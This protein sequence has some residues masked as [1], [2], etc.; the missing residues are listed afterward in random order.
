MEMQRTVGW[1]DYGME[2]QRIVGWKDYGMEMQRIVGGKD[3]GMEMQNAD[4]PATRKDDN[5]KG[6]DA[7]FRSRGCDCGG[8]EKRL[9]RGRNWRWPSA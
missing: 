1:K 9:G 6:A 4:P 5:Q 8:R 7:G 2:M 3:C